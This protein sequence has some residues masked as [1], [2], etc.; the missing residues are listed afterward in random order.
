[1]N[2]FTSLLSFFLLVWTSAAETNV[3]RG[4]ASVSECLSSCESECTDIESVYP[5]DCD[6]LC[7]FPIRHIVN[8]DHLV[9]YCINSISQCFNGDYATDF[10]L[11]ECRDWVNF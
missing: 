9:H 5:Q 2:F 10:V 8:E 4:F 11:L 6:T 7:N 3:L 1:M